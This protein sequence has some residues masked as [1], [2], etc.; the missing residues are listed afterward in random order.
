MKTRAVLYARMSDRKKKETRLDDQIL[1]CREY[2]EKHGY[3]VLYELQEEPGL[4]GAN[5]DRP[6]LLRARELAREGK[7][8]VLIA[9]KPSRIWRNS[10]EMADERRRFKE[11]DVNS[12]YALKQYVDGWQGD[13]QEKE[14]AVAAEKYQWRSGERQ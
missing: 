1:D 13:I 3:T 4:S 8:D 9:T 14:D 12:E 11:H 10:D 5:T 2:A 7:F 6:Q